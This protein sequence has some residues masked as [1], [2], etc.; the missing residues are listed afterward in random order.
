MFLPKKGLAKVRNK[1]DQKMSGGPCG[2]VAFSF[3]F[4]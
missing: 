2:L 1:L 4:A 3:L